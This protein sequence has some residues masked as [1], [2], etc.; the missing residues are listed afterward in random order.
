MSIRAAGLA[1]LVE[2]RV[3]DYREIRD[4]PFD[5]T[6]T[7]GVYGHVGRSELRRF[8]A[9]CVGCCSPE[10][11]SSTTGS[12]GSAHSPGAVTREPRATSLRQGSFIQ[13]PI[14]LMRSDDGSPRRRVLREHYPLTLRRWAANLQAHRFEA[15]A[16]PGRQCERAWRLYLL[17]TA[18]AFEAGEITV[19][20]KWQLG[21][22]RRM[23]F[24]CNAA[25][26]SM[27][28]IG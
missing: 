12:Q 4:G 6:L 9:S 27:G 18:Q 22:A 21:R 15:T 2:I 11:F 26:P 5:K 7:I 1:H 8:T 13:S 24:R 16:I 25:Q 10:V 20:R 23:V 3:P 28:R 17:G 19:H 14:S